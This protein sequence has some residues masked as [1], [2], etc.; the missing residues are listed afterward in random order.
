LVVVVVV[1]VVVRQNPR[2]PALWTAPAKLDAMPCGPRYP[3]GRLSGDGTGR[4]LEPERIKGESFA[5]GETY[6]Q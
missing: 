4:G 2:C 5:G 1:T 6:P 3:I